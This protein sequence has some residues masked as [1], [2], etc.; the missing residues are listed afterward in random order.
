MIS[1]FNYAEAYAFYSK[2]IYNRKLF[3][4]LIEHNLKSTGCIPSVYWELFGSILT[5]SKGSDGYG[6]DLMGYEIKS[7]T[8]SNTSYEYQYHL[9]SGLEKLQEDK[10]VDHIY[11]KYSADYKEVD[12]Y[13]LKGER[14]TKKIDEWIPQYIENYDSKNPKQRFRRGVNHNFVTKHGILIMQISN[15]Q[16]KYTY[17]S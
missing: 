4:L 8:L 15:C 16:V 11:C 10:E 2:Y 13:W 5:G 6:S 12:V 9:N 17:S 1:A 14:L 7:A 3:D